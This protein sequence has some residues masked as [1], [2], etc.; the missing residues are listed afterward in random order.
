MSTRVSSLE[1]T[2]NNQGQSLTKDIQAVTDSIRKLSSQVD[3]LLSNMPQSVRFN[4]CDSNSVG[5]SV[6]AVGAQRGVTNDGRLGSPN[7]P[8]E[9][10]KHNLIFFGISESPEG[11][12]FRERLKTDYTSIFSAVEPLVASSSSG[13]LHSAIRTCTHLGRYDS[14]QRP[15]PLVVKFNDFSLIPTILRSSNRLPHPLQL[16]RIYQR[17]IITATLFSS[18]SGFVSSRRQEWLGSRSDSVVS[19]YMSMVDYM[20]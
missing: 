1:S 6:Q 10:R 9:D 16:G 18:R 5:V 15:R 14:S 13:S 11:T 8:K 17:R 4:V 12:S 3:P 2:L 19:R 7:S 20:G